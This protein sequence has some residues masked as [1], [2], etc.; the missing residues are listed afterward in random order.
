MVL[1]V[2]GM[3]EGCRKEGGRDGGWFCRKTEFLS[4][5][6]GQGK[7]HVGE[8]RQVASKDIAQI[9]QRIR[10]KRVKDRQKEKRGQ[11]FK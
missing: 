4:G 11:K 9:G 7:G 10:G 8:R 3:T 5:F 1:D 2:A 6:S